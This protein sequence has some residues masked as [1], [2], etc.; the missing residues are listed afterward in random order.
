VSDRGV[1]VGVV[2]GRSTLRGR[3]RYVRC[4]HARL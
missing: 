4:L 3:A 2:A 1:R